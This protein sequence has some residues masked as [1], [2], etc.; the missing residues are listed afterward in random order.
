MK[1]LITGSLG[2]IGSSLMEKFKGVADELILVDSLITQRYPS[3]FN[4]NVKHQ[5]Y[6]L[7]IS[8]DQNLQRLTT[9]IGFVD[10]VIHLAARTD[11]AGSAHD[12]IGVENNNYLSTKN[13]ANISKTLN[14]PLIH[15]S[16]TS[17]YGTQ[18]NLVD[19]NCLIDDLKP[20]SPYAATKLKEEA[21]LN[22]LGKEGLEFNILRFGT[23]YGYSTGMRFHTAV[24][25]FAW[26]AAHNEDISVWT[27][28][29][30]QVR[31]YLYVGDAVNC[32]VKLCLEKKFNNE[33][34]NIVSQN[35]T[36]NRILEE[37]RKHYPKLKIKFV[38]SPIMNQLS[39]DV[40]NK[41][42]LDLGIEYTGDIEKGIKEI[43]ELFRGLKNKY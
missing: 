33:I 35:M 19:E 42:S 1:V 4:L 15:I 8:D 14:K 43:V 22:E 23:I 9:L 34:T 40:C 21:F 38:D 10:V 37:L 27:T 16:S 18:K 11:A 36:V 41:K 5:F 12:P 13:V 25:K 31:P 24:N 2:H 6:P 28:A 30:H 3:C 20:Q 26:Q 17:V 29:L 7:D 39:Y 32:L